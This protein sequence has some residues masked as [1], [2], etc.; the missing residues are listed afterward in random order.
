MCVVVVVVVVTV[1]TVMAIVVVIVVVVVVVV[2]VV[3]VSRS[4]QQVRFFLAPVERWQFHAGVHPPARIIA[5][6]VVVVVVV[7]VVCNVFASFVILFAIPVCMLSCCDAGS[8]ALSW[9]L[10][11]LVWPEYALF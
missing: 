11:E 2:V 5:S 10:S 6:L 1:I 9:H 4:K 7:A 8:V 3:I